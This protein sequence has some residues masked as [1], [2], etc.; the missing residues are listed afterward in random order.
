[1]AVDEANARAGKAPQRGDST[2][3]AFGHHQP[4]LTLSQGNHTEALSD[5]QPAQN[6]HIVD[7][8]FLVQNVRSCQPNLTVQKLLLRA[9]EER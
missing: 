9:N 5:E 4:L 6:R 8:C 7:A 1:M 2:W 3:I